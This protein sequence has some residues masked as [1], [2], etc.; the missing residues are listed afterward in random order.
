M[1]KLNKT[2]NA[3]VLMTAMLALCACGNVEKGE[4]NSRPAAETEPSSMTEAV[5]ETSTTE[6]ESSSLS[7]SNAESTP[8]TSKEE[9]EQTSDD[10]KIVPDDVKSVSFRYYIG[11]NISTGDIIKDSIPCYTIEITGDDLEKF[12]EQLPGLTKIDKDKLS[13]EEE[14]MMSHEFWDS[15]ELNVNDDVYMFIGEKYGMDR[16]HRYMFEFPAELMDIV[17]RTAQEYNDKNVYRYL[18]SDKMTVT[19]KNGNSS[20]VTDPEQLKKMQSIPYY[21]VDLSDEDFG[22]ETVAYVIDTHDGEQLDIF[23]ASVL[24]K[25]HH[26]DG[27]EEYVYTDNMEDYL[28]SIYK[29]TDSWRAEHGIEE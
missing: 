29:Y 16:D 28:D 21:A 22:D 27:T 2:K 3:L 15:Y 14:H 1:K 6:E 19:D 8:D 23:F 7:E 25:L 18:T 12:K 11:Y 26:A 4:T 10:G 9:S 5:S 13:E 17:E 24:G 20:E